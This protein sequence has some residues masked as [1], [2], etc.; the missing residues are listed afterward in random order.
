[1]S[2]TKASNEPEQ[3]SGTD[4]IQD[5]K[6]T[7][8]KNNTEGQA[9]SDPSGEQNESGSD[10]PSAE[11]VTGADNLSDKFSALQAECDKYKDQ[12]LRTL[13]E[14]DNYRKRTLQE[15]SE[16]IKNGGERVLT[17]LL[18]IV[19]DFERALQHEP[20]A[21]A[22]NA[23][24]A[25]EAGATPTESVPEGFRLIYTKLIDFLAKQGVKAIEAA[26]GTPFDDNFHEAVAM[27]P[28]PVPE[29]KGKVVECVRRGYLLNEKVIR[30][31]HVLV[32][33]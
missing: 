33:Q 6:Q 14:F 1:M 12:L 5:S 11:E 26:S 13:A 23:A 3:T 24:P 30:Y 32:G 22:P 7:E 29:L 19:D 25:A 17:E 10:A 2:T 15:K 16:L 20:A 21:A 8:D 27:I 9:A 31:A 4:R 28:A 18:T